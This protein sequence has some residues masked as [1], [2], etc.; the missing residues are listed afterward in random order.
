MIEGLNKPAMDLIRSRLSR[1][2]K[3]NS[4]ASD[5]TKFWGFLLIQ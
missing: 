2:E 5:E 4:C 3:K 1:K